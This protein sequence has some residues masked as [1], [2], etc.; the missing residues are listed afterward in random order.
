LTAASSSAPR[1]DWERG[2]DGVVILT[3]GPAGV[4]DDESYADRLAAIVDRLEAEHDSVTG[5]VITATGPT[6]LADGDHR[7]VFGYTR[8]DAP[9]LTAHLRGVGDS[10]R[11]LETLGRP[12]V[13]LIAGDATGDGLALVLATH[14][15]IALDDRAS[16]I[17]MPQV[18]LG[19]MA[20]HG[21]LVRCVRM[22]GVTEAL[23]QVL[24][25][26]TAHTPQS[27]ATLGLIDELVATPE[28]L[29]VGAKDWIAANPNAT[30]P[31]DR[32]GYRLPGG[33]PTSPR[34]AALLPA[35]AA[36][37]RRQLKGANYP[38]PRNTISAAVEGAQL[39]IEGAMIVETR[40]LVDILTG[41]VAKNMVQAFQI[42]IPSASR[43]APAGADEGL[44][45]QRLAILGAGMMGS[46]I[47]YVAA[48]AG[49]DVVL[50]DMS[51]DVAERGR[52]HA[53]R[54]LD[55]AVSKGQSTRENADLVLARILSTQDAADVAGADFVI[56]AVFEDP[57]VKAQALAEVE[58]YLAAGVLVA[59]NTST[60]PISGLAEHWASPEDFIGLH[61]F[62]PVE[63]MPLLEVV[64]GHRTSA[65]TLTRALALA[66]RLGKTPIVVNDSRGFFA[67]RVITKFIDEAMAMVLEGVPAAS[68]EQAASQAGY[69]SPALALSDELSLTLLRSIRAQARA[70]AVAEGVDWVTGPAERLVDLMV[71]T[72]QRAGRRAGAGFYDYDGDGKRVGLWPGL[73][74]IAVVAAST[75]A[76]LHDLQ[77]RLLFIEAIEAVRCLDEAV[78]ES[79]A[80][81]NVGSL[82]GIGFPPW[83]GG[84]L[85]YI[86]GY[87]GGPQGFVARA[88]ALATTYGERF[89]PPASLLAMAERGQHYGDL[90]RRTEVSGVSHDG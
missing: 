20:G 48:G 54:L 88:S 65:A 61:F 56:E 53:A 23:T 33:T 26:G 22:L 45:S 63:K 81:A 43:A 77:E 74:A 64:K 51:L 55:G 68:V 87:G 72:H 60:L 5:V 39:D 32:D 78:V 41:P 7:A 8:A 70:A 85:Q 3:V 66:R 11:R 67:S 17:A 86:N 31:W 89:D 46:G 83:T 27:A 14:H 2:R 58:P 24:L 44:R 38:A 16:T 37:L 69:P 1:I 76:P 40:Y 10:L 25:H 19:L 73:A 79:V 34:L 84:V 62:S 50:K 36:N 47:A 29:M 59:S 9:S 42:D 15:R 21:G 35:F 4:V 52:R 71:N 12:V 80:D 75:P 82:L 30:Q 49:I 13:A 6:A 57:G 18:R 90:G 28:D